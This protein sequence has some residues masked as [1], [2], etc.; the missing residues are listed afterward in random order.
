MGDT[1]VSEFVQPTGKMRNRKNWTF[2]T[3][4]LMEEVDVWWN[5]RQQSIFFSFEGI[6]ERW[7]PIV[8]RAARAES[9]FPRAFTRRLGKVGAT[10]TEKKVG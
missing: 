4:W 10:Y 3:L 1:R 6:G 2:A 9:R 5:G 8:L 7:E